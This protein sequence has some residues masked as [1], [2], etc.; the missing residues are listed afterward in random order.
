MDF[1]GDDLR[2]EYKRSDFGELVRGKYAERLK[3]RITELHES[4]MAFAEQSVLEKD[5][6]RAG[7]LLRSAFEK[8]CSAAD[9]L[10][11]SFE[12]E[13]T[14]SILHR[15]AATLA[16]ECREYAEAERLVDQ[17]LAGNPPADIGEELTDVRQRV[18]RAL[19]AEER[20]AR[21]PRAIGALRKVR[22]TGP[23]DT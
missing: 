22:K 17:G 3:E 14:R 12:E 8:E 7:H 1:E 23:H 11:G 16:A 5:P 15:S 20:H 18:R 9:L 19:A 6:A 21:M 10:A 13:P 4:A 2:P